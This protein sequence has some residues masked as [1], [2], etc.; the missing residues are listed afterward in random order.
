MGGLQRTHLV[1]WAQQVRSKRS[2]RERHPPSWGDI[3]PPGGHLPSWEDTC[4]SGKI[5]RQGLWAGK[6]LRLGM[7]GWGP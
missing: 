6:M 3:C 5:P 2:V 7:A 4:P 1:H